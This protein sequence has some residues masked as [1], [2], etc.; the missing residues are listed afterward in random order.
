MI[1]LFFMMFSVIS[2]IAIFIAIICVIKV[3][4]DVKREERDSQKRVILFSIEDVFKDDV[5]M[6]KTLFETEEDITASQN[7]RLAERGSV[8]LSCNTSILSKEKYN[9]DKNEILSY[10]LP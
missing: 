9:K 8:R 3:I 6:G 10:K 4:I 1:N 7:S 5:L 2:I